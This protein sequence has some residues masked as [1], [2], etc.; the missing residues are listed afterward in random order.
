[1]RRK[2]ELA[3]SIKHF[4]QKTE[5]AVGMCVFSPASFLGLP[6]LQLFFFYH[7]QKQKEKAWEIL[8][9]HVG[10]GITQSL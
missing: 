10:G 2:K 8:S 6:W 1:M 5:G 4:S 9:F 7:L 3:A